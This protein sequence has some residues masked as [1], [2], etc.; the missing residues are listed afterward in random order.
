MKDEELADA[1][2]ERLNN[3]I[4]DPRVYTVIDTL[5]ETRM[6]V[7]ERIVRH[8]TLQSEGNKLGV[9]GVLNGIVG[10]DKNGWG[11]ITAVLDDTGCLTHFK[12][13]GT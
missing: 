5:I 8:P 2:I 6:V 3:L 7:G 13:T 1:I 4:K 10:V 9:L 12:R 11:L